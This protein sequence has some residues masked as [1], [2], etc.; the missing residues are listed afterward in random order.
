LAIVVVPGALAA[1]GFLSSSLP[2]M[3]PPYAAPALARA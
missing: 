2:N 1:S 3:E